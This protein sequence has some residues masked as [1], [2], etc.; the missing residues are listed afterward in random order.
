MVLRAYNTS[1]ESEADLIDQLSSRPASA[2][3]YDPASKKRLC[4]LEEGASPLSL[5]FA[6]KLSSPPLRAQRGVMP[7]WT[8]QLPK[9]KE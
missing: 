9:W 3:L 7:S 1:C 5:E 4:T 8:V 6:A 2:M